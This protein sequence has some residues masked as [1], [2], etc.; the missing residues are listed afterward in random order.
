M[1]MPWEGPCVVTVRLSCVTFC[2]LTINVFF[3]VYYC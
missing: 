1:S 3:I 2:F